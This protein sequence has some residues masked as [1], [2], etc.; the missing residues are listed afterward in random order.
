V[1]R[2]LIQEASRSPAFQQHVAHSS[3]LRRA[4]RRFLPGEELD[5][6]LGVATELWAERIPTVLT[7][8]GESV[9]SPDA[10]TAASQHY[11]EVLRRIGQTKL[12][13][14]VS[15]KLSH[16]GLAFGVEACLE[17]LIPVAGEAK[18][19]GRTLWLDIEDSTT[20]DATLAT[21]EGLR[22]GFDDI[23][24][25]L[26]ANLRRTP[27]DLERLVQ[28]DPKVRLVKGAYRERA[29]NAYT[30]RRDVN[31]AFL[32]LAGELLSWSAAG[33]AQPVIATHD[34]ELLAEIAKLATALGAGPHGYE[35]HMLYGIRTA[36]LKRLAREGTRVRVLVSYGPDW[37]A[38]YL[39]RIA[40]RP[41]NLA[42]AATS[43]IAKRRE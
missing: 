41:A 18:T 33:R 16:L 21:F 24:I 40:E 43:L 37:A 12:P 4:S 29:D 36:D 3:V 14:D 31:A 2:E 1:I 5:D 38:W 27:T 13:T 19:V 17:N 10:A 28:L 20:T 22:E 26:Q 6:A 11:V 30:A 15:V 39:R 42:L 8:L 23:G 32:E 25:A 7:C 34:T 35:V 9:A